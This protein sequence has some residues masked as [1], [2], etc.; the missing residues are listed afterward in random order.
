M[1]K[2]LF[3]TNSFGMGGAEKVLLDIVSTLKNNFDIHVL[4]FHNSG[5]LKQSMEKHCKIFTLFSSPLHYFLFC[6]INLYRQFRIKAFVSG[7]N[8][9]AI[10]GF[11]EGKSTDL[12]AEIDVNVRKIAWVHND[13]RK[14][15]ILKDT[16]KTFSVYDKMD[17]IVFVSGDARKVFLERFPDIHAH[18][19]VIYNVIDENNII[20]LANDYEVELSK[21]TFLNVGM[22][23]K[24]KCQDRLVRIARRLKDLNYDFQILI[25]GGGPLLG[26]LTELITTSGVEDH[27]FLLGMNENPYP[28]MKMCNCFVQCSD[29]EGYGIA[30]KEALFLKKLILTTDVVGPREILN[31]GKYG[32][33]AENDEGS[34]FQSM[35]YILDLHSENRE[36]DV[37]QNVIHYQGDNEHI[38]Q[39][40]T[41]LFAG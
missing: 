13:F 3:I 26:Y 27:V 29:Y 9:K 6:R 40:L 16:A 15:E 1:E 2:I 30:I 12:V 38:R 20:R 14:L 4:V 33:I 37:L 39:Q 25:I 34:L 28:Y 32:L 7:K 23:R 21:F 24:Q 22:L 8:Y 11:M 5:P 41:A 35:R 10:V 19:E 31:D 36:V 17:T 18:L